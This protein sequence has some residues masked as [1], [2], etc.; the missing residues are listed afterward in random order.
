MP[1]LSSLLCILLLA[2]T[3][4]LIQPL[5]ASLGKQ[6]HTW[7]KLDKEKTALPESFTPR[8]HFITIG[9]SCC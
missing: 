4:I 6:N 1:L 3:V 5:C 2:F 7:F 8:G 9:L